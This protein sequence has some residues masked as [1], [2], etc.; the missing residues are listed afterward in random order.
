MSRNQESPH[1]VIASVVSDAGIA[2]VK[3]VVAVISGSAAM[4]SEAIHSCVD[5]FNSV[6]LIVGVRTSAR[7]PD[8]EHPFGHGREIYFWTLIVAMSIFAGG[9]ALSVYEGVKHLAHPEVLGRAW[10]SYLVLAAAAVFEGWAA[11]VAY[12]EFRDNRRSAS[13][14]LWAAF[15][16]SKDL[17]TFVVLFENGAA[18]VGVLIAFAGIGISHLTGSPYPDAIASLMIGALLIA[19]AFMLIRE[20]RGLLVGEGVDRRTVAEIRRLV[21]ADPAVDAVLHIMTMQMGPDEALLVMDVRF[22]PELTA[23]RLADVIHAL[24]QKVR[25]RYEDVTR[26]FI[27]TNRLADAEAPERTSAR[28]ADAAVGPTLSQA[29]PAPRR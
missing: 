6:F 12:R 20:S 28:G 13:I 11:L 7:P 1:S 14:G 21:G 27:Q 5:A 17:T 4:L 10:P 19:V 15:R 25:S 26:I 3:I 23:G 18:L 2:I 8:D 9:G 22:R 29:T 16:A 24:E